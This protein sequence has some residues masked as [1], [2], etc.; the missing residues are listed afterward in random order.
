MN[1]TRV[2][3]LVALMLLGAACAN[4][5]NENQLV[6]LYYYNPALDQDA[7]GN[8]RCSEAGLVAVRRSIPA[9]LE[10]EERIRATI[11]LL[12]SNELTSEEIAQGLSSEFPLEGVA[13]TDIALADGVLTLT[14]ADPNL[15]TSGGACRAGILWAQIERT[16][17]QFVGVEQVRFAPEFLF[18]P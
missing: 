15:A 11:E 12:L 14:F 10:G 2:L 1:I 4:G 5:V 13:L 16:A 9:A 8:I 17:G 3:G 7:S 6:S 18:Q